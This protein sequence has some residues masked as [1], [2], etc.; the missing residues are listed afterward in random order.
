MAVFIFKSLLKTGHTHHPVCCCCC[1]CFLL[2]L[3]CYEHVRGSFRFKVGGDRGRMVVW[4]S[5]SRGTTTLPRLCVVYFYSKTKRLSSLFCFFCLFWFC[6]L[7][8]LRPGYGLWFSPSAVPVHVV[9]PIFG[10]EKCRWRKERDRY[11]FDLSELCLDACGRRQGSKDLL[12]LGHK[13][14]TNS[15]N[16]V[17]TDSFHD[18]GDFT[19]FFSLSSLNSRHFLITFS[20]FGLIDLVE[21]Y[22]AYQWHA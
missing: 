16:V 8:P 6:S 2:L 14:P 19:T 20:S 10:R 21:H 15:T 3:V 5:L 1:C 17:A 11:S 18:S 22:F 7:P 13:V 4:L 12:Q 9:D